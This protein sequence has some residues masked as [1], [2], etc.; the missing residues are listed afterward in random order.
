VIVVNLKGGLGNQMF[1]Y[2]F[3]LALACKYD[4]PLKFDLRFLRDQT[5]RKN[6][7][8]RNYDLDIFSIPPLQA[9][10]DDLP[11]VGLG[12]ESLVL[13]RLWLRFCGCLP[14]QSRVLVER[15]FSFDKNNL[16]AGRNAYV[17]GY[18]QS[19]KYFKNV[20]TLLR[21]RFVVKVSHS[22]EAQQLLQRIAG[23]KS[24]CVNVRRGDLVNDPRLGTLDV[25]YFERAVRELTNR[26]GSGFKCYV[27]SDDMD[28]CRR[29]LRF[30]QPLEFVGHEF[31]GPKFSSYFSLMAACKHFI[32]PNSTF[33]WWAAWLADNQ[34]KIVIGPRR[35]FRDAAIDAADVLP[36]NWMKV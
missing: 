2:A 18:W 35:W 9:I 34:N 16:E 6:L 27:F 3:G 7:V 29:N 4:V 17:D 13:Q 22:V 26:L 12:F 19:E 1:Q 25:E 11:G 24:V 30:A 23:E 31:S 36:E 21:D 5:P 28:W 20:E 8:L 33:A 32:I 14:A 15:R 10:P